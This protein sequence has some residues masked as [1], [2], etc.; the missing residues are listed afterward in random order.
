VS[1]LFGPLFPTDPKLKKDIAE[2]P[3]DPVVTKSQKDPVV[4]KSPKSDIKATKTP[5]K[6]NYT[7]DDLACFVKTHDNFPSLK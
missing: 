1:L 6:P 5:A 2:E 4:M 3:E 7:D